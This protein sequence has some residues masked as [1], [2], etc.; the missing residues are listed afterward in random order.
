MAIKI[1]IGKL[2]LGDSLAILV[3]RWTDACG[4]QVISVE[5][6]H[7]LAVAA[8]PQHHRNPFDRLLIAQAM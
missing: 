8:L 6:S 7:A 1:A 5:K 2:T 3:D 4:I